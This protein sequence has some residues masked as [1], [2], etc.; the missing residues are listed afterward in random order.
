MATPAGAAR[1]VTNAAKT[2]TVATYQAV[3]STNDTTR[4][5]IIILAIILFI[6]FCFVVLGYLIQRAAKNPRVEDENVKKALKKRITDLESI[7]IGGDKSMY[8]SID[9]NGRMHLDENQQWLINLCPLTVSVGG[10]LG[11]LKDGVFDVSNFIQLSLQGGI[12]SFVLPISTYY[13]DNKY[14]KNWPVSGT[15]AIVYRDINGKVLSLNAIHIKEFCEKLIEKKSLNAA[16]NEEPILIFLHGVD[17]Y[18]PNE[19]TEES[20]YVKFMS[21]IA[22]GLTPLKKYMLN[23][24][25]YLGSVVGGINQDSIL[26]DIP[27]KELKNKIIVFTNFNARL[28]N[29][30]K[31][32][33]VKPHL[34]D[35]V[36]YIYSPFSPANTDTCSSIN[37]REINSQFMK[38]KLGKWFITLQDHASYIPSASDVNNAISLGAQCIPVPFISGFTPLAKDE[39]SAQDIE[40]NSDLTKIYKQWQGYAWRL[41]QGEDEGFKNI[42]KKDVSGYADMLYTKPKPIEP[43]EVSAKLNARITPTSEP[44]QIVIR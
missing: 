16:Q 12:R 38:N 2:A 41:R 17:G 29:H 27:L 10:Y 13:D 25:P 22:E 35:Y 26:K 9:T 28:F 23:T 5:T 24:V 33:K 40:D 21:Q 14:K 36:N 44:G 15:P 43:Q 34:T 32:N 7:I 3:S 8:A 19:I 6:I 20:K 37:L 39:D 4:Y 11:P 1:V 42:E 18:I 30:K 31:Y